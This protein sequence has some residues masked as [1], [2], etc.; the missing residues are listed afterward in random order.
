MVMEFQFSP[1]GM[2]E[3]FCNERN[4]FVNHNAGLEITAGQRTMSAQK[5][6]LP[7]QMLG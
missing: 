1:F 2:K 4:S 5:W 6:V 3:T 7:G